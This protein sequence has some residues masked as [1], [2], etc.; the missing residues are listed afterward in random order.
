[1]VPPLRPEDRRHAIATEGVTILAAIVRGGVDFTAGFTVH[2]GENRY[3][4]GGALDN[5]AGKD[6]VG[7][8]D[9]AGGEF[10]AGGEVHRVAFRSG[11]AALLG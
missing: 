1:M 3:G 2:A 5:R 7:V 6:A 10:L 4:L 9:G 8:T 11:C